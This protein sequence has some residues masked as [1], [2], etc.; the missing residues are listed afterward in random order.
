MSSESK[1]CLSPADRRKFFPEGCGREQAPT[2]ME[3]GP[4]EAGR[5]SVES[6]CCL[7]RV[8]RRIFFPV[9]RTSTGGEEF[10]ELVP[11]KVS[12][13]EISRKFDKNEKRG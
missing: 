7:S 13:S 4:D 8:E 6:K 11:I 9:D 5:S 2:G 12:K 1:S 10:G 3:L